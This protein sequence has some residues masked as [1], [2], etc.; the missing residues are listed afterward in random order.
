MIDHQTLLLTLGL[1]NA[2]FAGLMSTYNC[3]R[4]R[5]PG[6]C[7]WTLARIVMGASQLLCWAAAEWLPEVESTGW[8]IGMALETAAY[9]T[10]FELRRLKRILWPVTGLLML[11]LAAA[12]AGDANP[13]TMRGLVLLI[14]A[15]YGAAMGVLLLRPSNRGT[16]ALQKIIGGND[17]AFAVVLACWAWT[18]RGNVDGAASMLQNG[19]LQTL[20]FLSGYMIMIVNGFGFLLM[21]KQNDDA[22]MARLATIDFLT[23]LLNRG[24]FFER[25]E[26]ARML[27]VRLKKP[28]AL[29]MLDID[30]FKEINDRFGHA[31]G[32]QAL[33][34]FADTVRGVLR[35][36]DI[37]GRLG[38]EEFALALP[39]TDLEGARQAA[40]RL[41]MAVNAASVN[42]G[43]SDYTM[44]VSIGV[45]LIDPAE[46]LTNALARADH[47]L[48]AAKSSGRNRVEVA[49]PR[50]KEGLCHRYAWD[51]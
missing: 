9:C 38:G 29:M 3:G 49:A 51:I 43:G 15:L 47:A 24:A 35:D 8:I 25:A 16:S 6:L 50:Q 41:R 1:G 48:Y 46:A 26:S 30:H 17:V 20:A 18:Q 23:G 28:I 31:S 22:K 42:I 13:G 4:N 2:C 27:A 12:R 7:L 21:C 32:D 36:H 40:E 39:G 14:V 37:M 34:V 5:H 11:L 10:V 44:T 19:Q 45:V 33:V